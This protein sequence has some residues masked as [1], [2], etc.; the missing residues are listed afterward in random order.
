MVSG[1]EKRKRK[2]LRGKLKG[3]R[4]LRK[5]GL[6]VKPGRKAKKTHIAKS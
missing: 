1:S 5:V 3:A 6:E 4:E 2:K